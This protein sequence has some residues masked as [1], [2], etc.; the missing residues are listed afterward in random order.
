MNKLLLVI[1][2]VATLAFH[3][4]LSSRANA[5]NLVCPTV[6]PTSAALLSDGTLGVGFGY[7]VNG[8]PRASFSDIHA[9]DEYRG[10]FQADARRLM[11]DMCVA[12]MTKVGVGVGGNATASSTCAT[13]RSALDLTIAEN[14]RLKRTIKRLKARLH[15][16]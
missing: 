12:F 14:I 8:L 16:G 10:C 6:L 4:G 3:L 11:T 9:V 1:F 5:Q 15:Q 7:D 2:S 13:E